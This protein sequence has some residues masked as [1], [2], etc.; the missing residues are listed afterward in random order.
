[1]GVLFESEPEPGPED[2]DR[3]TQIFAGSGTPIVVSHTGPPTWTKVESWS[4]GAHDLFL[5]RGDGLRLQRT[6][7]QTKSDGVD[8]VRLGYHSGGRYFLRCGD[9]EE[10]GGRG[11]LSLTDITLPSDFILAGRAASAVSFEITFDQLE[12]PPDLVRRAMRQLSSSPVY[13]LLQA[14]MARLCGAVHQPELADAG[15]LVADAT[16]QLARAAI[17]SAA[18]AGL[19]RPALSEALYERIAE[20]VVQHLADPDLT[21]AK[22]AAVHNISL[23]HLYRLWSRNEVGLAEWITAERLAGAAHDLR[24]PAAAGLTVAFIACK[25]GFTDPG[26]FS[27]RFRRAYAVS[28]REWRY[29]RRSQPTEELRGE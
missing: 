9:H 27:R 2:D 22:I 26:H 13:G 10:S 24:D 17:V 25:W 8:A 16:R 29:G 20:Y 18:D 19:G 14:H 23:R 7:A 5:A 21:P 28:P 15:P 3:L 1:M 6:R 12:V 11:R 4:I